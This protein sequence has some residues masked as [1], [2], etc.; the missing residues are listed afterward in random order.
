[1]HVDVRKGNVAKAM[2][3]LNKKLLA[4]GDN[5][6]AV[7]RAFFESKGQKKRRR[8]AAAKMR[9]RKDLQERIEQDY[10]DNV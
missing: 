9:L 1:M 6:R 10:A 3:I 7:E 4:D 8:L 2:T 5:R